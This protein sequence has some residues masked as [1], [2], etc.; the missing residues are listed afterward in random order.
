MSCVCIER[1]RPVYGID[2]TDIDI[3]LL[4]HFLSGPEIGPALVQVVDERK[5]KTYSTMIFESSS[6][7]VNYLESEC[8]ET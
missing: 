3:C 2:T 6:K 8:D 7:S 4:I 5:K 1:A